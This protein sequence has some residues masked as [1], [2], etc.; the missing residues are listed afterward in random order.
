MRGIIGLGLVLGSIWLAPSASAQNQPN[1][2]WEPGQGNPAVQRPAAY[3][4]QPIVPRDPTLERRRAPAAGNSAPGA[5]TPSGNVS[6]GY[7]PP[8]VAVAQQPQAPFTLSPQ[9]ARQLD[10]ILMFW[11][12]SSL[13]VR[14]FQCQFTRLRYSETMGR[15]EQN[16]LASKEEG[17]IQFEAPAKVSYQVEGNNPERWVCNGK[18]IFV[19]DY[20][21]KRVLQYKLPPEL[22][23]KGI[24]N[25]PLPF[26]FGAARRS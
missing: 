13:Q 25:G 15:R 20:P 23:E 17:A 10:Q 5:M 3:P 14:N 18:S 26:L 2:S 8:G 6:P 22:Q 1:E 24:T 12:Q 4:D 21:A 7:N 16:F 9:E 19:Y 11:E